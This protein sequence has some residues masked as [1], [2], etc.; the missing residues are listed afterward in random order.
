[1][2]Y[3]IGDVFEDTFRNGHHL[4]SVVD[5]VFHFEDDDSVLFIMR[6]V[7]DISWQFRITAPSINADSYT[8][9]LTQEDLDDDAKLIKI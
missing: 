2:K 6:A 5:R 7:N 1:M 8:Y 3:K 4:I 9:T